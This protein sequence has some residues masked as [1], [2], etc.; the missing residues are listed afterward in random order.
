ML[1][2]YLLLL[3]VTVIGLSAHLSGRIAAKKQGRTRSNS[4]PA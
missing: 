4:L 2:E 3:L 1:K